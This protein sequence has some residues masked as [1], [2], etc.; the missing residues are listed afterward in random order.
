MLEK[1]KSNSSARIWPLFWNRIDSN[2]GIVLG[3]EDKFTN[4][5]KETSFIRGE[6]NIVVAS[7][8][9]RLYPPIPVK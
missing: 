9:T 7:M 5:Q 3:R 4:W 2:E 8:T 1:K 6:M